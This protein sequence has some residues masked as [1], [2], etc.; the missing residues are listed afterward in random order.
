MNRKTG[1]GLAILAFVL[2]S[3][4]TRE[5][6]VE[7]RYDDL[8]MFVDAGV[9]DSEE[10]RRFFAEEAADAGV[11]KIR[12]MK[13]A[14]KPKRKKHP[15]QTGCGRA[16]RKSRHVLIN[17]DRKSCINLANLAH[18]I[19]HIPAIARGCGGH[20]PLFYE[21]NEEIAERFEAKFPGKNW[22]RHSPVERVR[23]RAREYNSPCLSTF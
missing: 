11:M 19:A 17:T 9:I 6:R 3:G 12:A 7:W 5:Q 1:L 22:G 15:L 2:I 18:E 14:E 23:K 13:E 21:I 16:L 20:G 10:M 4:C 8:A